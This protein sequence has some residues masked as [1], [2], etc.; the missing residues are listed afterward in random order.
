MTLRQGLSQ[1]TPLCHPYQVA[2]LLFLGFD[3]PQR[4]RSE[5]AQRL[6]PIVQRS[7]DQ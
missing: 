1:S 6:V 7:P 2:L 5:S 4:R 3:R